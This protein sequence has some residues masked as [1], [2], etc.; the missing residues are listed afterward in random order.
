M[1]VTESRKRAM[2]ARG[3]VF[4]LG[5]RGTEGTVRMTDE[6]WGQDCRGGEERGLSWLLW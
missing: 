1:E 3:N 2:L 6:L 5:V 4:L